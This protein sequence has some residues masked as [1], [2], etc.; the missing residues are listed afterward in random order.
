MEDNEGI[1][2][3]GVSIPGGRQFRKQCPEDKEGLELE[4]GTS[5]GKSKAV[6]RKKCPR[7]P[8]YPRDL[9]WANFLDD[10]QGL[11]TVCQTLDFK[12]RRRIALPR[13]APWACLEKHWVQTS[14][15]LTVLIQTSVVEE[16]ALS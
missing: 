10:L 3:Q 2:F 15:S 4:C 11:S 8:D 5:S 12:K 16:Q 13:V 1:P 9:S 7:D 14:S 6:A